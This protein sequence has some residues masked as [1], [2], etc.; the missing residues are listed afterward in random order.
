MVS[1]YSPRSPGAHYVNQDGLE[2]TDIQAC[3]CF[4]SAEVKGLVE[5]TAQALFWSKEPDLS[6]KCTPVVLGGYF[7]PYLSLQSPYCLFQS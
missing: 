5:L 7:L 6:V 4:L 1:L 3:L 2:L